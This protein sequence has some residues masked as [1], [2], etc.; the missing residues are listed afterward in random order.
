MR[1]FVTLRFREHSAFKKMN[2]QFCWKV[3][4]DPKE[5]DAL[6]VFIKILGDRFDLLHN[7]CDRGQK[8]KELNTERLLNKFT[9]GYK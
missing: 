8:C 5:A 3:L 4:I 2:S 1:R 6:R 9:W 7:K